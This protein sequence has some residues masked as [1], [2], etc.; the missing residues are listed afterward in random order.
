MRQLLGAGVTVAASGDGRRAPAA[1]PGRPD[2]LVTASLLAAGG[3]LP[4]PA[5]LAAVTSAGRQIMGLPEVAIAP[6]FPADLVA[7]RAVSMRDAMATGAPDRIVVR[8][9][10]VVA[11]TGAGA[12]SALP[13][14][15]AMYPV[16]N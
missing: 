5:A 15:H 10:R 8:G 1:A 2:P 11:R 13:G 12:D 14:F 6:G 4:L 3:R 7:V 9:G 16:W